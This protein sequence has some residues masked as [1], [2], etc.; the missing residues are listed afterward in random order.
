[1][2]YEEIEKIWRNAHNF[3]ALCR[4]FLVGRPKS[5]A[6]STKL[7]TRKSEARSTKFESPNTKIRKSKHENPKHEI[8]KSEH[9]IRS[10][11]HEIR[12]GRPI[13][14]ETRITDQNWCAAGA[15]VRAAVTGLGSCRSAALRIAPGL[16]FGLRVEAAPQR[17]DL[18]WYTNALRPRK[19]ATHCHAFETWG[20]RRRRNISRHILKLYRRIGIGVK[21]IQ[22]AKALMACHQKHAIQNRPCCTLCQTRSF[23]RS[24]CARSIRSCVAA[25]FAPW[26]GQL[27]E[28]YAPG[29]TRSVER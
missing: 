2:A 4:S 8:R 25:G 19:P 18:H 3:R 9:E 26:L 10:S 15:I 16:G 7:Q 29:F 23:L 27:R 14:L 5:E 28:R 13:A 12:K 17:R 6:R 21:D 11:K 22:R 1:M 24:F 20:G